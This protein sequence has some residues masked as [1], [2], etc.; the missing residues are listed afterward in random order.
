MKLTVEDLTKY[1]GKTSRTINKLLQN[2][3]PVEV[4][5]NRKYY[6]SAGA[7]FLIYSQAGRDK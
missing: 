4:K 7:L 1:T 3:E 6:D 5:G 2:L